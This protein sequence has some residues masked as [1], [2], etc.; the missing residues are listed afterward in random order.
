M[1]IIN[2]DIFIKQ[3]EK[4]KEHKLKKED[5]LKMIPSSY[6]EKENLELKKYM[7]EWRW[8]IF[9]INN[10]TFTEISKVEPN[11]NRVFLNKYNKWI[12]YNDN[13]LYDKF[14]IKQFYCYAL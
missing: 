11:K 2:S 10:K 8:R 4:Y 1:N 6:V 14:I 3:S 9:L 12:E 7:I 13:N 5:I